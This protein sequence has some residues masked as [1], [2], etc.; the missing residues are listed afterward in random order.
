MSLEDRD[1]IARPGKA[2]NQR[3]TGGWPQQSYRQFLFSR[4]S[5]GT[6]GERDKSHGRKILAVFIGDFQKAAFVTLKA[7]KDE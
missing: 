1:R 2:L 4:L 3:A 7:M 5:V 6:A